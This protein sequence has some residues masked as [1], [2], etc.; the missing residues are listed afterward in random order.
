ME[1]LLDKRGVSEQFRERLFHL[2]SRRNESVSAFGRRCGLDRSAL[3]QFLD[4]SIVRLPRA[5]TLVSISQAE[6][7]SVDWLLGISQDEASFGEVASVLNIETS[8]SD[9]SK[10]LLAKWHEEAAG[11]KIRYVP[12]SLP[13]F[14]RTKAVIRHEFASLRRGMTDMKEGLQQELLA[15]NRLPETD[16]EAIMPLQ[17]LENLANGTDIWSGLAIGAR[18]AQLD[19]IKQLLDELY[20]TFRLFLY[21]GA[22]HFSAPFTVFGPKRASVY[23]GDMYLVINSVDHIRELAR[24]FDALIRVAEVSPD[25][26]ADWVS[27]LKVH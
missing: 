20:P 22:C 24:R 23:L 9:S 7:V 3:S 10:S 25:R 4:Q 5:E 2:I 13:D 17:R 15:Y 1:S 21:D 26:A 18:K 27:G 19:T 6:G 14:F 16:M 12:S 8:L 11:Y